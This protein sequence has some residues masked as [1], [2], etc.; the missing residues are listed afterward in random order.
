LIGEYAMV[1]DVEEIES[2]ASGR[3]QGGTVV[4]V[5]EVGGQNDLPLNGQNSG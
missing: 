2:A 5:D 4:A 1:D 3:S